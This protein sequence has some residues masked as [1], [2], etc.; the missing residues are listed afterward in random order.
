MAWTSPP[1]TRW[2]PYPPGWGLWEGGWSW[3][4]I[5]PTWGRPV[6]PCHVPTGGQFGQNRK[7]RVIYNSPEMRMHFPR[8]KLRFFFAEGGTLAEWPH[9]VVTKPADI[10]G[11]TGHQSSIKEACPTQRQM[12]GIVHRL[13]VATA[14]DASRKMPT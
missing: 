6:A 10:S 1:E 9:S 13:A 7:K 11:G 5:V 2:A 14:V 4:D 3:F 8:K 12:P